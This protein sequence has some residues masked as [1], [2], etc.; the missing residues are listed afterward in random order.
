MKYPPLKS[1]KSNLKAK[2]LKNKKLIFT[3]KNSKILDR[4]PKHQNII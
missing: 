1:N 3:L 2:F 4:T